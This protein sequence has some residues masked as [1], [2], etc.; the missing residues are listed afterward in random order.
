MPG[1]DAD[2]EKLMSAAQDALEKAREEGRNRAVS[3]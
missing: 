2:P 3:V 1:P